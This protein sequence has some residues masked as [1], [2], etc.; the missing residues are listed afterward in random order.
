MVVDDNWL[1]EGV[2]KQLNEALEVF[3]KSNNI[4]TINCRSRDRTVKF[5]LKLG[6]EIYNEPF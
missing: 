2:G 4:D 6:L 5:Y 1:G 3:V